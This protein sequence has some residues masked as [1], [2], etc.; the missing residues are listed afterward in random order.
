[1]KKIFMNNWYYYFTA[2]IL[3]SLMLFGMIFITYMVL[4]FDISSDDPDNIYSFIMLAIFD[5]FGPV[6]IYIMLNNFVQW[7][8]IDDEIIVNRNIFRI[9]RRVTWNEIIEVKLLDINFST[10]GTKL[11]WICLYDN[12]EGIKE[13]NGIGRKNSYIMIRNTKHNKE[14]VEHYWGKSIENKD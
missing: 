6:F 10:I 3:V 1:M 8:Y 2:L 7:T 14:I 9:I 4:K 13:S 5:V 12:N 11:K